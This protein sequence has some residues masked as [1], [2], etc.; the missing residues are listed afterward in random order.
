LIQVQFKAIKQE[1]EERKKLNA[2]TGTEQR[3]IFFRSKLQ[4]EKMYI[5]EAL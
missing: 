1:R 5:E 2:I 4:R 3:R